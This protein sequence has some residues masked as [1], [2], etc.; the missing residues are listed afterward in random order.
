MAESE[1]KVSIDDVFAAAAAG[2]LRA[3]DAR[4]AAGKQ[5]ADVG[6]TDLVKAGF[7]VDV[8][9]RAGGIPIDQS[10]QRSSGKTG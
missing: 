6:V 3:L 2:V 8:I 7:V 1:N 5:S 9:I 4:S 10:V